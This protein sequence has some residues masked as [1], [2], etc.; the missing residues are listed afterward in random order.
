[1][2]TDK[3]TNCCLLSV[4]HHKGVECTEKQTVY[5]TNGGSSRIFLC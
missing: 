3:S 2:K 4:L 5:L 1:M